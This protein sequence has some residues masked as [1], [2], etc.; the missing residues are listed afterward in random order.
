MGAQELGAGCAPPS[1]PLLL[2]LLSRTRAGPAGSAARTGEAVS[3]R[4]TVTPVTK[5]HIPQISSAGLRYWAHSTDGKMKAREETT[6]PHQSSLPCRQQVLR[7][8]R[9]QGPPH[10]GFR[11][12]STNKPLSD[13]RQ[14]VPGLDL[15]LLLADSARCPLCLRPGSWARAVQAEAVSSPS[16]DSPVSRAAGPHVG[17]DK[18]AGLV[19]IFMGTSWTEFDKRWQSSRRPQPRP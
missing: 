6:A 3:R 5:P 8:E 10:L 17:Q 13:A 18:R 2:E 9:A 12:G 15:S 7:E 16:S 14:G 1:P 4:A 11:A 19:P